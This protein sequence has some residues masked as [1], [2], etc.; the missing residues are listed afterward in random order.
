[1]PLSGSRL[2]AAAWL[3][4][5]ASPNERSMPMTSPVERISGPRIV[6]T[7]G[8]RP[9]GRTASL[10][11]TCPPVAGS[12]RYPLARSSARV[13]PTMSRAAI[14]ARGTPVALLTNGTV[15]LARGFASMI[16]TRS[17]RTAYCTL[18]R[19]TTSS[20][21]ASAAVCA[22]IV[23]STRPTAWAAESRTRSRPECTPASSMC[24]MIPPMSTSPSQSRSASTST[25]TASSRKRSTSAGRSAERPP[26]RPRLPVA[27]SSPIARR[28]SASS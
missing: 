26:S 20:A 6:S 12:C 1:M 2:P 19:P 11:E 13:A 7:S 27:V 15:R 16:Q 5:N 21:P 23:A 4:T 18:S 10:T 28:R 24:S 14:L 8:K 22:S 25:S 3:F 17:S 9:N